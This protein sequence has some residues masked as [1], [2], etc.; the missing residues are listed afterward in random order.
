M[1]PRLFVCLSPQWSA[2]MCP[3]R[4]ALHCGDRHTNSLGN[5]DTDLSWDF[6]LYLVLN[7]IALHGG[8]GRATVH[9][10]H[11]A[12]LFHHIHTVL[13]WH[14]AT[15]HGRYLHALFRVVYFLANLLQ[16][17][18][19]LPLGCAG[20]SCCSNILALLFRNL[21]ADFLL[22]LLALPPGDNLHHG[23]V[24]SVALSPAGGAA[25]LLVHLLALLFS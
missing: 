5:I 17:C 23:V 13:L 25:L 18:V 14:I 1:F 20:A 3:R 19:A 4:L 7:I 16:D 9:L 6:L 12:L 11:V 22:H 10:H 2:R 21:G 15:L 24:L 8:D